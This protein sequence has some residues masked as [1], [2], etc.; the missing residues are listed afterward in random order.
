[1]SSFK[2]GTQRAIEES[3]AFF[4]N[5]D[6]LK[7][8]A[9]LPAIRAL[10]LPVTQSQLNEWINDAHND[11][12]LKKFN[13]ILK[14]I[15]SKRN[16]E[17]MNQELRKAFNAL[18]NNK[19]KVMKKYLKNLLQKTN[20]KLTPNE[21]SYLDKIPNDEITFSQFKELIDIPDQLDWTL[22]K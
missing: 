4:S 2:P 21:L 18:R 15:V 10:G 22:N 16:P 11:I 7:S 14:V 9:I 17:N 19:G 1:M 12:N 3:F 5:D 20:D 13:K 6:I 8:K